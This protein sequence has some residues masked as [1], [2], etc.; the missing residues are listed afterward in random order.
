MYIKISSLCFFPFRLDFYLPVAKPK[1]PP[2]LPDAERQS[3]PASPGGSRN[4]SFLLQQPPVPGHPMFPPHGPPPPLM[5]H[6]PSMGGPPPH[7]GG[8]PPPIHLHGP[9]PPF[10]PHFPPGPVPPGWISPPYLQ[11][12]HPHIAYGRPPFGGPDLYGPGIAPPPL[13]MPWDFPPQD[14]IMTM[15]AWSDGQNYANEYNPYM[16][17]DMEYAYWNAA[18]YHPIGQQLE[19][20]TVEID[21][22]K[23]EVENDSKSVKP[24]KSKTALGLPTPALFR[25]YLELLVNLLKSSFISFDTR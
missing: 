18:E 22:Q 11:Q 20:V 16:A 14:E 7:M 12:A 13:A 25:Q 3:P 2:A 10:P 19:S 8:P 21:N 5:G 23:R 6:P 9:P 15:M 24:S 1:P 17:P 4:K